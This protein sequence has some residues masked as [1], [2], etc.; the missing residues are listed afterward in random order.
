MLTILAL[1]YSV[2]L[3]H[4]A[5]IAPSHALFLRLLSKQF[6]SSQNDILLQSMTILLE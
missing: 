6:R 3:L 1:F 2:V 5:P 4:Y